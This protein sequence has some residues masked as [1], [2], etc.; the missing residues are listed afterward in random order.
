MSIDVYEYPHSSTKAL[1][2]LHALEIGRKSVSLEMI[3]RYI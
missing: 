1:N 3:L 2:C